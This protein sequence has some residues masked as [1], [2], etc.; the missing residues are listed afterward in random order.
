MSTLALFVLK[1]KFLLGQCLL[2]PFLYLDN[3]Q[4]RSQCLHW[5]F[6]FLNDKTLLDQCLHWPSLFIKA[7]TILG[8]CL[9]WPF[10][11][12]DPEKIKDQYLHQP[13]LFLMLKHYQANVCIGPSCM[14]KIE[15]RIS[16]WPTSQA[17]LVNLA[18]VGTQN[19]YSKKYTLLETYTC[20]KKK[21]NF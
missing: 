14:K 1:S 5:P 4:L 11:F 6:L 21:V 18:E 7:I 13:F 12:S 17:A 20:K 9:L 19:L 8:Q 10:L 16:D 3:K 15:N 2:W